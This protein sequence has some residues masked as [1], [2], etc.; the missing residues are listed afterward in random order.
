MSGSHLNA[1][2]IA[3]DALDQELEDREAYILQRCDS[4]SAL[5]EKVREIMRG[6][7]ADDEDNRPI[8]KATDDHDDTLL[9]TQLGPFLVTE[10]I[11]KGGMGVVYRGERQGADFTQEVALKLIRRGFDFD[12]IRARFLRERRIL[13]RLD[14]PNLARFI[15]GGFAPD[16]RPWFALD[17]VRGESITKWC[18]AKRLSIRARVKLFQDVCAAVQYAHSRLVVHRD[19]KP[20]NILVDDKGNVRLLDFGI[21]RLLGD[22]ATDATLTKL[23][24]QSALTPEYAA[25][26]QFRGDANGVSIDIYSLGV[27]LYELLSGTLPFVLDRNDLASSEKIILEQPPAP[28]TQ[29]ITRNGEEALASRLG[30]RNVSLA[31]FRKLVRGDLARIIEKAMAKEPDRRYASVGAFSDDLSQWLNGA[32]VRV[33][34][35]GFGY[36]L[37][38]FIT[39]N[40]LPVAFAVIAFAAIIGGLIATISLMHEARRQRDDAL[41]EAQRSEAMRQYLLLMFRDAATDKDATPTNVR[42]VFHKASISLFEQFKDRPEVGQN[43]ASMLSDIYIQLGDAEGAAPLL[44][45]L[46]TW[47]GIER[48]PKPQAVARY[49]MAQVEVAR[50]NI[51]RASAFLE[52]AQA[53]WAKDATAQSLALLNESRSMEA[54]IYRSKGEFDRAVSTLEHAI[55]ERRTLIGKEDFEL[56]GL[57]NSLANTFLQMGRIEDAAARANESLHILEAVGGANSDGILAAIN[58]R[59]QATMML[60]NHEE[61]LA[62]FKRVAD[63]ALSLFGETPKYASAINNY[64]VTLVSMGREHEAIPY[65]E[66]AFRITREQITEQGALSMAVGPSLAELY[67]KVGRTEEAEALIAQLAKIVERHY[68]NNPIVNGSIYRA[69][70]VLL[71]KQNRIAEAR[72]EAIRARDIYISAG[73]SGKHFITRLQ[74]TLDLL[75]IQ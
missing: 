50:G 70:S 34:G 10:R 32:P 14:H 71:Y 7:E 13:A 12:D 28:L 72:A 38:K 25:P 2:Q 16:G 53:F 55:S 45:R 47:P 75:G 58:T 59:A 51:D 29:A 11:G 46:L 27:I 54:R 65:L 26:E 35:N 1:L 73:P 5:L 68:A 48:N 43:T 4:D 61:A 44:E 22:E 33:S 40:K 17:F 6:I 19:L 15:D 37:K 36:R 24:S 63:T 49:N 52:K 39:R 3:R 42:D 74:P 69:R 56:A 41:A 21:A 31:A 60:G 23:G 64:G 62:D 67:A 57:Y 18:D 9:G 66:T 30:S 20:G 8:S